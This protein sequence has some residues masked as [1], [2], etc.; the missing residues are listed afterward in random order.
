VAVIEDPPV[1]PGF[2][3]QSQVRAT[4]PA[5]EAHDDRDDQHDGRA[6]L[7]RGRRLPAVAFVAPGR[8]RPVWFRVSEP[9]GERERKPVSWACFVGGWP[10]FKE[11]AEK[12]RRAA[13]GPWSSSMSIAIVAAAAIGEFFTAPRHPRCS[14]WWPKSLKA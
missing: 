3:D 12:H 10:I 14:C 9:L 13:D 6:G 2:A 11:A 1:R 4:V 7:S 8:G 5:A